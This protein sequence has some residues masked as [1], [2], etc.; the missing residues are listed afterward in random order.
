MSPTVA[1]ALAKLA[2]GLYV[3][4]A[5][6]SAEVRPHKLLECVTSRAWLSPVSSLKACTATPV[7]LIQA[8]GVCSLHHQLLTLHSA[9]K[10]IT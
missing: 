1:K 7:Q 9:F 8:V 4:T 6:H 2:N 10:S 5:A 3:V